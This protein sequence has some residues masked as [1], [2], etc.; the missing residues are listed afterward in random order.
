MVSKLQRWAQYL[1]KFDYNIEHVEGTDKVFADILKLWTKKY[2]RV[3]N[4]QCVAC[5][6][7]LQSSW[8]P[9]WMHC[10]GPL[11]VMWREDKAHENDS[12]KDNVESDCII[13]I[14]GKVWIP[15]E[16]AE[17]Q[18]KILMTAHCGVYGH[19][20][21]EGMLSNISDS[22]CWKGVRQAVHGLV[23]FCTQWIVS[24]AGTMIQG[25]FSHALHGSKPSEVLHTEFF[26][27][28]VWKEDKK[29]S[30][31]IRDDFSSYTWIFPA[32]AAS[33]DIAT[34]P[35]LAWVAAFYTPT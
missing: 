29:Y 33:A 28:S 12:M 2:R 5:Y 32:V 11:W 10:S 23:K 22:F 18:L 24:R 14:R 30:L 8:Y 7:S 9:L 27:M 6:M 13:Y 35:L 25:T 4:W 19:R 3:K 15:E 34:E 26:Y 20:G 1:S 17:L 21:I 16:A 31:L